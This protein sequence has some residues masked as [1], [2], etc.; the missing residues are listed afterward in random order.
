MA[1]DIHEPPP[2]WHVYPLGDLRAHVVDG[3]DGAA[4]EC[5]CNPVVERLP[6]GRVVTHHAADNRRQAYGR[7]TA[8]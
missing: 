5:W 3:A 6:G 2:V 1:A 4:G 8:N 7:W